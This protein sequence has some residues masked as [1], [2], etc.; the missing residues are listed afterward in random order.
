[1]SSARADDMR[2]VSANAINLLGK[3]DVVHSRGIQRVVGTIASRL[4][5]HLLD[6]GQAAGVTHWQLA[7]S[8]VQCLFPNDPTCRAW[9]VGPRTVQKHVLSSDEWEYI[10]VWMC[11]VCSL[12]LTTFCPATQIAWYRL[13]EARGAQ[14]YDS[15]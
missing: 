8:A 6:P 11:R 9:N 2:V 5:R 7:T 12:V 13:A 3:Q 4:F 10:N 14:L 15:I 1:M